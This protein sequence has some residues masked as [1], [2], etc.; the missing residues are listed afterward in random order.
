[1][2]PNFLP[3]GTQEN[4]DQHPLWLYTGAQ[5]KALGLELKECR[6]KNHLRYKSLS[7]RKMKIITD[8]AHM[9]KIINT[10][11]DLPP[12]TVLSFFSPD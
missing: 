7:Y 5:M 2:F 9:W 11:E 4:S 10:G 3:V 12:T 8:E 6:L 1:M